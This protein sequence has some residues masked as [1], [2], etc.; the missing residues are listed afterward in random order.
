[1]SKHFLKYDLIKT[2]LFD[3]EQKKLPSINDGSQYRRPG[4]NRHALNG[5]WIL[6]PA[7][8]PI[9][10]RR[11]VEGTYSSTKALT[12][13]EPVNEGFADLCLTTWL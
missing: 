11:H 4:S 3:K 5:H 1:M 13:F 8:L 10:P 2:T 6:S 9:P 7:R 12:G